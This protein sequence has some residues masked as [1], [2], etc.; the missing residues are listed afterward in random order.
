MQAARW[1]SGPCFAHA[2]P[3]ARFL[4]FMGRES[5]LIYLLHQPFCCAFLGMLLYNRFCIPA[6]VTM[7]VC[8]IFSLGVSLA[9]VLIRDRA[10]DAVRQRLIKVKKLKD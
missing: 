8:I 4:R 9:A 6:P 3:G 7:A 1:F 10:A 2:S 5:L